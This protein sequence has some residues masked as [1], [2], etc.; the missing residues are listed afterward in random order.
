MDEFKTFN[1]YWLTNKSD[2]IWKWISTP[3]GGGGGGRNSKSHFIKLR[4]ITKQ[5]HTDLQVFLTIDLMKGTCSS[6]LATARLQLEPSNRHLLRESC[7]SFVAK[8]HVSH[9][10]SQAIEEA[11]SAT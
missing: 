7:S 9:A 2:K 5:T 11:T 8:Q 4:K 3:G 6:I 10:R 1:K